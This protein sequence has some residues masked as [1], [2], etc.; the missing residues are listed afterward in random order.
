VVEV[1]AG[2]EASPLSVTVMLKL[3]A[4]PEEAAAVLPEAADLPAAEL[5]ET[6]RTVGAL[7]WGR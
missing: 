7:F 5:I 2:A 6:L 4:A 1:P 3:D